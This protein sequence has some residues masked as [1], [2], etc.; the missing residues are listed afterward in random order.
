M[1]RK[2]KENRA[3]NALVKEL[4]EVEFIKQP[5]LYAMVGA[6]FTL[7]QRSIMIEIINSLQSQFNAYLKNR[8]AHAG[9]QLSLFTEQERMEKIKTFRIKAESLGVKPREYGE[10]E[11]A[12]RNLIQMNFSFLK[13]DEKSK[14]WS[15]TYQNLFESIAIPV[16]SCG[17]VKKR[18]NYVEASVS[19]NALEYL[20]DLGNGRGYMDHIYRIARISKRKR[21]PSIYIYLSRWA[22]DFPSKAVDYVELKKFLGV[23]TWERETGENERGKEVEKDKYPKFSK[24]CRE[25]MDPIRDELDSLA[26]ENLVDFS[27]DYEPVYHNGSRRGDPQQLLFRFRLSGLGEEIRR[28]RKQAGSVSDVWN[29]LCSEFGLTENDVKALSPML[30]E[31]RSDD[32]R[33]EVMEL[34]EKVKRYDPKNRRAYVV[35]SVRNLLCDLTPEDVQAGSEQKEIEKPVLTDAE[36]KRWNEFMEQL[37]NRSS[38]V[39]YNTWLR[40][41]EYVRFSG[42]ELVVKVPN[43]FVYEYIEENLI[44]ALSGALKSV[45][46]RDVRLCY[47]LGDN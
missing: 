19:V 18:V 9:E 13:Y 26:A 8:K 44:G 3:E 43:R 47:V 42:E 45:F 27:F 38:F 22:K 7:V 40:Y 30:P 10:L 32:F 41:L 5:Y 35:T 28:K 36:R 2:K 21:T 1:P 4:K 16:T 17:T 39:D 37:A 31:E 15:R 12:C 11:E 6:D 34:T 33:R 14:T 20:C 46:G 23:I 24:F 29:L 25:V